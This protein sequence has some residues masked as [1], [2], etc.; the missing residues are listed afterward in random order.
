M[1]PKAEMRVLVGL[2][3]QPFVAFA[4]AFVAF[5]ALM[6]TGRAFGFYGASVDSFQ[7]A[8]AVALAAAL[9]AVFV[10]LAGALPMIAWLS[11]RGPLTLA[12]ALI[13]GAFLGNAPSAVIL[14][15]VAIHDR[16]DP[17]SAD[18]GF[19]IVRL[20]PSLAFGAFVG[21]TCALAFWAIARHELR[22]PPTTTV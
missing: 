18:P 16:N 3:V 22:C 17:V 7:T 20:V 11:R 13:A 21:M 6:Y 10:S 1:T 12:K 14:L 4:A 2:V 15:L 5:P 8:R 19:S 9:A